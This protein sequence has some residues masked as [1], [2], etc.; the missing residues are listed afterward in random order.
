MENCSGYKEISI[1][2]LL[3]KKVYN[4]FLYWNTILILKI[5]DSKNLRDSNLS[6]YGR[7]IVFPE[8]S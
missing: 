7:M 6:Q 1:E 4:V 2:L 5:D 3:I 8:V